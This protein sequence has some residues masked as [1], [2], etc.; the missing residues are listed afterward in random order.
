MGEC[1]QVN[2][3]LLKP[4]YRALASGW[5][6][7][8]L[9]ILVKGID[10]IRLLRSTHPRIAAQMTNLEPY[11]LVSNQPSISRDMS[12][13]TGID[14]DIED[15]CEQIVRVLGNDAEL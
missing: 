1:G 10:D 15:I 8:R 4:R 2:L 14:T 9:V 3:G 7:D 11:N 6:L 13:V 12:I 5:G